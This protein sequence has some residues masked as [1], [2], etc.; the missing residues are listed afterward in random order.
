MVYLS[1]FGGY[2]G[3]RRLCTKG[4][5]LLCALNRNSDLITYLGVWDNYN[6]ATINPGDG[7]TL[8]V[9]AVNLNL[10]SL[11]CINRWLLPLCW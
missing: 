5:V 8:V 10:T 2:D 6:V 11:P 9:N 3:D 1:R 4:Y 7:I